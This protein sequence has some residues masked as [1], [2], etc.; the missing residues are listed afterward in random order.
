M[1][2][3]GRALFSLL[4]S[5]FHFLCALW[6][7]GEA[8]QERALFWSVPPGTEHRG[9][10]PWF[11]LGT[12]TSSTCKVEHNCGREPVRLGTRHKAESL[13]GKSW[14]PH[15]LVKA[16]GTAGTQ[17]RQHPRVLLPTHVPF[18]PLWPVQQRCFEM[19]AAV[20]GLLSQDETNWVLNPSDPPASTLA[21]VIS[22][23][24]WIES[25]NGARIKC[26]L[27]S[28]CWPFK[29]TIANCWD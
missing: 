9:V 7:L 2:F 16:Q 21:N 20:S 17:R 14:H 18:Q 26:S 6:A 11:A 29:M 13:Q 5:L 24:A 25:C 22:K 23:T 27:K 4:P 8:P 28:H 15:V 1:L 19:T 12:T 10:Q 3:C